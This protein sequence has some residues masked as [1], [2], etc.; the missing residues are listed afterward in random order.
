MDSWPSSYSPKWIADV[1]LATEYLEVF[2]GRFIGVEGAEFED[3][4]RDEDD[5][6]DGEMLIFLEETRGIMEE[7]IFEFFEFFLCMELLGLN[8]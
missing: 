1:E 6:N 3:K 5:E 8:V 4:E 2:D 7:K